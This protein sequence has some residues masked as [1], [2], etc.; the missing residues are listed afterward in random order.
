MPRVEEMAARIVEHRAPTRHGREHAEAEEA[1][2]GFGKNGSGNA[3]GG[4]RKDRLE[5][6][7]SRWRNRG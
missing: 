4:L 7:G 5:N 1:Q 3:D 2:R 6:V